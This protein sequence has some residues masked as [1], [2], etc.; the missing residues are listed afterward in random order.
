MNS[1][2]FLK[3]LSGSALA[4][5]PLMAGAQ[6]PVLYYNFE[7]GTATDGA[8]IDNIVAGPDGTLK[9]GTLGGT[10][11]FEQ[12]T[13]VSG[14]NLGRVLRLTPNAIG[15]QNL[16]APHVNTNFTALQLGITPSTGYT[17]MAWVN[18]ADISG[19][20]ADNMIFGQAQVTGGAQEVLHHGA[21]NASYHSG[22]WAD[23][24]TAPGTAPAP[25]VGTWN[26]VAYTNTAAGTQ[27]IFVNGVMI[28]SGP[29]NATNPT[30]GG[31]STALNV[32]IGT[33][34]NA[35]SFTGALDEIKVY[36]QV[37]T[38]AQIQQASVIPEPSSAALLAMS[39]VGLTGMLRRRR[40]LR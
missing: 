22:H 29:G 32:L 27:E 4:L 26:H 17:A 9:F 12:G 30:T 10:V 2:T 34:G 35:G 33:S 15:N 28:A 36:N 11:A 21:R 39:A 16:E 14:G 5:L 8:V 13:T 3:I 25:V 37:L 24:V 23:D 7:T 18:F 38:A 19:T 20:S 31:M 1:P 6:T 40:A